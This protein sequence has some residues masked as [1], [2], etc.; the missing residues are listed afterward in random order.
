VG[1]TLAALGAASGTLLA[2]LA[3]AIPAAGAPPPTP[4]A[5]TLAP[6]CGPA[7][8]PVA[9]PP[10]R[11][12]IHVT[13]TDFN[14]FHD[15]LVTFDAA[16]GGTPESFATATDGF[17]RFEL[18]IQPAQRAAGDHLVRADDF[19]LREA[20]ANFAVPCPVTSTTPAQPPATVLTPKLDL[21]P[22]LGPTGSLTRATGSGFPRGRPVTLLWDRGLM[23]LRKNPVTADADG[24]FAVDIL[25]FHHDV[26]GPR[27]LSALLEPDAVGFGAPP[28][29]EYLVV[30][31]TLQPSGFTARR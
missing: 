1:R 2:S 26:R 11:Y 23:S 21:D 17:G 30:P 10:P 22:K 16:A 14:P 27:K 19:R 24:A 29:A 9:G 15:V 5:I 7:L 12:A 28:P 4:A 8:T 3:T 18:D 20:V 13:G 6:G 31:G 25:I